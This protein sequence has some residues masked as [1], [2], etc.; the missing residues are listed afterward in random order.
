VRAPL[1]WLREFAP[2]DGDVDDLVASLDDLGLMVEG[3][4]LVGEGLSDIVVAEVLEVAAISG[5]DRIRRVVVEAGGEPLEIVCG[6]FNFGEGDL[7]PLA[8]V[9]TVLPDGTV[10]GP[11]KMRGVTSQGMLCSGRELALSD[12]GEGLLVLT[13][14]EGVA[15]GVPLIEALGIE[16]DVVFDITVEGN[17]PDAWC[18]AGIARDLAARL[19]V[20][21]ALPEARVSASGPPV[22]TLAS[23]VVEAPDMCP[24]LTVRVLE[25][26]VVGPSPALVARRLTMAGM[27]PINNVVDASNYVMLELGQPTHPYDLDRLQA[28]GL[29][30]RRARPGESVTTLDGVERTLGRP[31]RGLGETGEDCLICDAADHPVGI[32]GIFGGAS[33]E[34]SDATTRVLLEAAYFEPMGIAR[35]SKSQKLRTEA[36]ARFERGCDPLGI[37]RATDRFCELLAQSSPTAVVARGTLDVRGAL[38][39]RITIS[40]RADAVN[41]LLG[42]ELTVGDIAG[43]LDPI[44]FA[45]TPEGSA[46]LTVAVPS[47]RPDVRPAPQGVA[48]LAEEVARTYGYA[49]IARR[50]PTWAQPGGLNELQ[51]ERR[52]VKEV[53][54]GLGA[55]EAWT[56]SLVDEGDDARVGVVARPIAITNP[57]ASDQGWLRRTQMAG[58]LRALARNRDRRQGSIRLFEVGIVFSEPTPGRGAGERAGSGGAQE[59]F[60]PTERELVSVLLAADGDDAKVAVAALEAVADELRLTGLKIRTTDGGEPLP[61]L[62]PTRSARVLSGAVEVGTLGEIDPAVAADFGIAEGR[63]GWLELDLGLV[64]DGAVVA[65]RDERT[66]PVSRYP[67]SDIDLALVVDDVIPADQVADVLSASG[68]ELLESVTLFDVYR[69]PGVEPGRRSL[70]FRLRFCALDRTLTDREVGE[71]RTAC[72]RGAERQVG[73]VLR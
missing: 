70:A 21:F 13:G 26:V 31:G 56:P 17:R 8:K 63:L 72:L 68:G 28:P 45:C 42:T 27:R 5:A 16:P 60:L 4:E 19:G 3:V 24:R 2:I 38:P 22:E 64:A 40:L 11:R 62:H 33:S 67:S 37:D 51:R 39:E 57:M 7:V 23:A 59:A 18:M 36:S 53:L 52:R 65:R 25:S 61:G 71:L 43:L 48:D 1:S 54:V 14:V 58:L 47:N 69:G 66:Q 41:G 12:D 30:V 46:A 73:A 6:A 50:Q 35:T 55:M 32:G 49:R 29:L 34:I 44:G 15:A 20:P 10:I 9:G